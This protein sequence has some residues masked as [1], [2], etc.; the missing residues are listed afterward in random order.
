MPQQP[1]KEVVRHW[2]EQR[3]KTR[4]ARWAA[5]CRRLASS[6]WWWTGFR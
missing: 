3:A 5:L 6:D 4:A 1:S 2:M